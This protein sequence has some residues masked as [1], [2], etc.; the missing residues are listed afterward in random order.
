MKTHGQLHF[1]HLA[2]DT[3]PLSSDH[4]KAYIV[5]K[6]HILIGFNTKLYRNASFS[7]WDLLMQCGND[8]KHFI[9]MYVFL[10]FGLVSYG[11]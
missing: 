11:W 1:L 7:N 3:Q 8:L 4:L 5:L 10:M 6:Y 9:Y 2:R